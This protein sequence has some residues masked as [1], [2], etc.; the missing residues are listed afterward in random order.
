MMLLPDPSCTLWTAFLKQT[1]T[2]QL[3]SMLCFPILH[4]LPSFLCWFSSS[5]LVLC[6][7]CSSSSLSWCI[8]PIMPFV[9]DALAVFPSLFP[10]FPRSRHAFS[11]THFFISWLLS[12][13]FLCSTHFLICALC[14]FCFVFLFF[15]FALMFDCVF[16]FGH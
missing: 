7:S 16:Q 12:C 13:C 9:S 8:F 3:L 14:D 5:S 6:F 4:F 10:L 11:P 1:L 15:C 2:I